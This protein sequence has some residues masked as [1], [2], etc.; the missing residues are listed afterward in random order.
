MECS[1][2]T[3]DFRFGLGTFYTIFKTKNALELTQI[4]GGYLKSNDRTMFPY[5]SKSYYTEP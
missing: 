4:V 5:T 3:I 2:P 1:L